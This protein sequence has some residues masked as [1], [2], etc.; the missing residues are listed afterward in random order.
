MSLQRQHGGWRFSLL[1]VA[2]VLVGVIGLIVYRYQQQVA[3]VAVA[4][5]ASQASAKPSPLVSDEPAASTSSA[6]GDKRAKPVEESA[7]LSPQPMPNPSYIVLPKLNASDTAVAQALEQLGGLSLLKMVVDEERVRKFVRAVH[8]LS[9]GHVVQDFRPILSPSGN[10]KVL[11]TGEVDTE[12]KAL[13]R[14]RRDNVDRYAPFIGSLQNIDVTQALVLYQQYYPLF[15]EAYA[16]LGLPQ[17]SFHKVMLSAT[18]K[19][20]APLPNTERAVLQQPKVMYEY[21]DPQF[22]QLSGV[23]KLL[24]RLSP[25]QRETSRAWL[26]RWYAG[27]KSID[28]Q[29]L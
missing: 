1:A 17:S 7:A 27:L 3:L 2:I 23:Q 12:G 22:E 19:C 8:G 28:Q 11:E 4:D 21:I 18:Q 5:L 26:Q 24:L 10:F 6:P 16:E 25:E 29:N 15:D 20:L 14:M 9:E 13:Y